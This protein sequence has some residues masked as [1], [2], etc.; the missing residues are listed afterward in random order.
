MWT[1]VPAA[2]PPVTFSIKPISGGQFEVLWSQGTLME[3]T[4]LSRTLEHQ[5]V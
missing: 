1:F 4:N 3:A 2:S 5:F